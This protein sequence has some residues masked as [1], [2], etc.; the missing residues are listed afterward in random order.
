MRSIAEK[1]GESQEEVEK[2]ERKDLKQD[3]EHIDPEKS[4][5]HPGYAANYFELF[6]Q[7][8]LLF[9]LCHKDFSNYFLFLLIY[10]H[11]LTIYD[12]PSLIL[13]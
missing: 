4:W 8:S 1:V 12:I 5:E 13:Q 7:F 6:L 9:Y 3:L 11:N 2:L 10:Q